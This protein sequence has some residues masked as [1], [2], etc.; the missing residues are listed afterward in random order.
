MQKSFPIPGPLSAGELLDRTF[1]LYRKKFGLLLLTAAVL[2]IPYSIVAGLLTGDA[3][4]GYLD[5]LENLSTQPGSSPDD[6]FSNELPDFFGFFGVIFGISIIGLLFNAVATLALT[7]Q[8]ITI[9]NG[10]ETT[11]GQGLRAGVSRLLAYIGM[12]LLQFLAYIG[13]AIGTM[14]GFGCAVAAIMM[15]FGGGIALFDG[16]GGSFD[17][18]ADPSAAAIVG[19]II[20][21]LC[22]YLLAILAVL[23]PMAYL[24]ARWSV[25]IPA[26][27]DQ[28][29]GPVAALGYSWGL[30][31]GHVRRSIIY[32]V[33]LFI[34]AAIFVSVPTLVISQVTVL[35]MA[36]Q[37]PG[38][39]QSI[40]TIISSI[41]G[42]VWI[43]LY[44]AAFVL[45]Y[46]D[47]RVRQEGFDLSKRI[48]Q[49]ESGLDEAKPAY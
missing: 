30:T 15:V 23:L 13:V 46:Y 27:V 7:E 43:P 21:V 6:L 16:L 4:V 29:L 45:Y 49:F 48:E 10:D 25:A 31:K 17:G 28:K 2:I 38:L 26:L 34:L 37:D 18:G 9:L 1:R 12:V 47:L 40:S 44:T 14:I 35:L 11:L 42:V 41:V 36:S 32:V 8:E 22:L 5:I 20:G 33:L 19:I 3:M 39:V 24:A